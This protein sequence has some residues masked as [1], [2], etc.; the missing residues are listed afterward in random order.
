MIQEIGYYFSEI[1]LLKKDNDNNTVDLIFKIDLEKA[2]IKE[3]FVGDKKLK[4]KII[5]CN[6]IRRE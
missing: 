3:F 1:E 2:Y 6:Y 4:K 5:K